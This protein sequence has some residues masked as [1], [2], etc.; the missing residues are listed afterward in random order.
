MP[1]CKIQ[2]LEYFIR[3]SIYAWISFNIYPDKFICLGQ[4]FPK[5]FKWTQS[6]LRGV[7]VNEKKN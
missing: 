6:D 7:H 5:W 2:Y 1:T 3:N 4:R